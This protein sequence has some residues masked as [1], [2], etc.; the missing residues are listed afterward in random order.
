M[1]TTE[2]SEAAIPSLLVVL[3]LDGGGKPIP[4]DL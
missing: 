3:G 4:V 2:N 1:S